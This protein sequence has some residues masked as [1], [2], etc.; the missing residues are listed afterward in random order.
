MAELAFKD[1]SFEEKDSRVRVN[2]LKI[3]YFD[4]EKTA[5][6]KI[7]NFKI[8]KNKIKFKIYSE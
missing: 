2:F 7:G 1:L 8:S 4:I 6:K 3:F 5:F